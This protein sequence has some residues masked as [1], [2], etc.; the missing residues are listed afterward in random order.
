MLTSVPLQAIQFRPAEDAR[1]IPVDRGAAATWQALK[2][3]H[4]RASIMMIVA[5]PD[6]EDG[7]ML[8]YESRGLGVRVSLLTLDRGEGGAN[9]MSSDLWDA[10]GLV[11]TEELLQ[12]GRYYGLD[13]QYFTTMADY[14]FSKSLQ[15]ALGQWGHD[16]VLEEAVRVVRTVRP[17][18]VCSV[19]VG[20]PTDGHGQ[21]ATA[22]LLA[23]EVF[24][25]AGDPKMFPDQIK[26]GL[27]PWSP[28]KTYAR[29][30][31]F[32]TS[33]KGSYDYANHTWGQLGVTNHLTGKWEPGK[34]AVTVPVPS[35]TYDPLLGETYPQI[36]REGLGF[37]RSQ[38]GGP[39]IP[40][41]AM[42]T[43]GYHRFGSR[44]S[45]SDEEQSFFDGI[46]TSLVSI[47]D[48]AGV[49][50]P[51]SFREGLEAINAQVEKAIT[52]FAP[53]RPDEIVPLLA[54]GLQQTQ[55][56]IVDIKQS[57]LGADEKY[58]VLHELHLKERQFNDAIVAALQLSLNADVVPPGPI[59]PLMAEFRGAS[60]TFEMAIP[61]KQFNIK[62][63]L[64][65][66]SSAP[67][68]LEKVGLISSSGKDWDIKSS[69]RPEQLESQKAVDL[70]YTVKVPVDE[71]F[72]RPYF[73]RK[74]LQ[75]AYY[76][77]SQ[78]A[79]LNAPQAAYPLYAEAH[80]SYKGVNIS[81]A[82]VVQVVSKVNGPG[83][84]RYPMPLGPAIS[85]AMS[86]SA[87]VIPLDVKSTRVSARMHNNAEGKVEILLK[88][89]G[90]LQV[91]A[92]EP[93]AS[94]SK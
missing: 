45:A 85:V 4:T 13:A 19:F 73:T 59:N 35:G 31:F 67:L 41:A 7:P 56:L 28:I 87:G 93:P 32:R 34:V 48:L 65:Q 44:I 76:Q 61:G 86:P 54:K 58:N 51:V 9:V 75:D 30:P 36:S 29:V 90:K 43:G 27:L 10:L 38:N 74:G 1:A 71:P 15:E 63:H 46:D 37:Q 49:H 84:L 78:G 68:S 57:K 82:S 81:L 20:G 77:V 66:A 69:Q 5:H 70:L 88:Q 79:P 80:F 50:A 14:G 12:A 26:A 21:H 52:N 83:T 18:V 16:R 39:D 24:K 40:L 42:Q 53:Q 62:I 3:L 91:E 8:T 22:G 17:L 92:F 47:A 25:A 60:P 33:E 89:N 55:S 2:R 64:Y 6:D 23:Q 94:A 72:T 11:R